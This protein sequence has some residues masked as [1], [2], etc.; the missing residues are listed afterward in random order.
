MAEAREFNDGLRA[1]FLPHMAGAHGWCPGSRASGNCIADGTF[2]FALECASGGGRS[3]SGVQVVGFLYRA[4][5]RK[6]GN[7]SRP[8]WRQQ[9]DGE[10][11]DLARHSL[12]GSENMG[13][14]WSRF[15]R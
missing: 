13:K 7:F 5:T 4:S 6:S 9:G 1:L 12:A 14:A 3:R 10:D 15:I 11:A 8:V 2:T